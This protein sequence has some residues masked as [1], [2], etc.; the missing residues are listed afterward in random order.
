MKFCPNKIFCQQ[1]PKNEPLTIT[2]FLIY[3]KDITPIINWTTNSIVATII[4]QIQCSTYSAYF[5]TITSVL[6]NE[7]SK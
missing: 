3:E 1:L 4:G 5:T 7:P 6:A 2:N